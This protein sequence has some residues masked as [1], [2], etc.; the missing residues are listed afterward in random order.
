MVDCSTCRR[1]AR[2]LG[3]PS[4]VVEEELV[5]LPPG[6]LVVGATPRPADPRVNR[7]VQTTRVTAQT[8]SRH[9][10]R[11]PHVRPVPQV[12]GTP[13]I[14]S[15]RPPLPAPITVH[16][17]NLDAVGLHSFRGTE[18]GHSF[19]SHRPGSLPVRPFPTGLSPPLPG[20]VRPLGTTVSLRNK[21]LLPL[22]NFPDFVLSPDSVTPSRP[23][24]PHQVLR[25]STCGRSGSCSATGGQ[26]VVVLL[27]PSESPLCRPKG[28]GPPSHPLF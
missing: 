12:P 5:G 6:P 11:H 4:K 14:S 26:G 16:L 9:T 22:G 18:P 3:L 20:P 25:S 2:R 23:S 10:P 27:P 1:S 19:S 28:E 13:Y 15:L 8:L 17:S 24:D 21:T 7:R